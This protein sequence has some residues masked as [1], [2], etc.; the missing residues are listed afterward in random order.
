MKLFRV[1]LTILSLPLMVS[2]AAAQTNDEVFPAVQWNFS[3][4]GA[5]ASGMG[6]TF[7]GLADDASAAVTNP[8]GLVNLT[9][10]QIYAE[11]KSTN[12]SVDRLAVVD[13]IK[14]RIP[15]AFEAT[16]NA[17]PFLSYS[18]PMGSRLAIG[19]SLNQFLNY[20]ETFTLAART[21]VD[22]A[23]GNFVNNVLRGV[24]GDV[25]LKATSIA[26]S[27]AFAVT[28]Q[29]SIGATVSANVLT[30]NTIGTRYNTIFGPTFNRPVPNTDVQASNIIVNQ[31][32]INDTATAP[33][34]AVGALF[35]PNEKI[36]AGFNYTRSPKFT[37]NERF[38]FNDS[39]TTNNPLQPFAAP[40]FNPPFADPTALPINVP[41][42]FGFGVA[43]RP[44]PR[45][46]AMVDVVGINYSSLT[47]DFLI[48][49]SFGTPG[50]NPNQFKIDDAT[51]FHFG[52]E[53]TL[54]TGANPV[55]LRA[56][57]FTDPNHS[58]RYT[59]STT[60]T[61]DDV[62]LNT[63]FDAVYNLLPRETAV[64]GTVGAGVAIGPRVQIDAAYVH[65]K[66]FVASTAVRF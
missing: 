3:T 8:A 35:R 58:T 42:R 61:G 33:G 59:P 14:T 16:V 36:S 47:D 2:G 21:L 26:G 34:F 13:S 54:M 12:I 9:K 39:T 57:V 31:T 30:A 65:K 50:L 40:R 38:L 51:E 49:I 29:F 56:G 60:L 44:M 62:A 41:D 25:E 64:L 11:F 4:P 5:R 7:I 28:K 24:T 32:S 15:T 23:T 22:Q 10:P 27:A 43:V 45:L 17:V 48:T 66:Q 6:R 53:Y 52:G 37:V 18:M 1:V 20:R 46:L 19:V 63:A 55:F